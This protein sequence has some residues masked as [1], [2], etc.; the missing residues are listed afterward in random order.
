M[1]LSRK[2]LRI[3]LSVVMVAIAAQFFFAAAGAFGA[4]SYDTHKTLGSLIV[5]AGLIAL[6]LAFAARFA[7]VPIAIAF[8]LLVVQLVLGRQGLD[9]PWLGALHGLN[10]L[11]IAAVLGTTTGRAWQAFRAE[12]AAPSPAS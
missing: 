7:I 12:K 11:A 4:M 3:W 5:V 9:H 2:V 10:A 1:E 8:V 6:L